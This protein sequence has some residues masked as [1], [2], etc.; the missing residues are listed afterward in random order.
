MAVRYGVLLEENRGPSACPIILHNL[1]HFKD[2]IKNFSGLDNYS[3]W[4]KERAVKRYTR[5]PSNCKNIECTFAASES[6][7]ES[8]KV[9]KERESQTPN[10]DSVNEDLLWAKSI[11]QARKLYKASQVVQE[12]S[13][14]GIL[15][16]GPHR[17]VLSYQIQHEIAVMSDVRNNDVID[18]ATS[19]RS[20]WKP[21]HG[22]NGLLYRVREEAIVVASQGGEVSV[23]IQKIFTVLVAGQSKHFLYCSV[24]KEVVGNNDSGRLVQTSENTIVVPAENISRKI[25]VAKADPTNGQPTFLIV[26]YMRRIFP[27]RPGTVVVPY[28]PCINDMILVRGDNEDTVW[29]ARVLS[30]RMRRQDVSGCFF[31]Q[32]PDRLWEPEGTRNQQIMFVSILGIVKGTWVVQFSRWQDL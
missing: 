7:R 19:Y 28:F 31:R 21:N 5:N 18:G 32:R 9:I 16:G 3:C 23:Q 13:S 25:M 17:F 11:D 22:F 14:I 29:R 8:L 4:T 27:V 6:R 1:L 30:F 2:D 26:D 20:I 15:V 24:F 10:E 12:K